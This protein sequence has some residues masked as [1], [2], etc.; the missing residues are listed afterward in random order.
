MK[1]SPLLDMIEAPAQ[2]IVSN[3]SLTR[4]P[5]ELD[6][7]LRSLFALLDDPDPR[8]AEVVGERIRMRGDAVV[9]PLLSFME[10][11]QDALAKE[12]AGKIADEFTLAQI[13]D[14]FRTLTPRFMRHDEQ[15]FEDGVF[16]IARYA[17]PGLDIA[18][19]RRMLDD[20]ASDLKN[21]IAGLS[22]GLEILDEVNNFFFEEQLF[23]G[24]Q[25]K[26]MEPENSY[27]DRVLDRRIGIPISLAAIYL[28]V[29]EYRLRL[30]F[31]GACAPGHFLIRYDGLRAEPLFV[32]AFNGGTVL[33][34]RDIQRYLDSTGLPFHKEF[35][36]PAH[37]RS[38]ILRMM[39]NLLLV[40]NERGNKRALKHFQE[41]M[42]ILSP[43]AGEDM[44]FLRG[45]EG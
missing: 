30:P 5:F 27:I 15:A 35:L 16:L 39:R 36:Q 25:A 45:L 24:N 44:A 8:V 2:S 18:R 12:R 10:S 20:M 31:S 42:R 43:E 32:D 40:F 38:I 13:K 28:L 21:H 14:G 17:N 1:A 33:R 29:V 34:S 19:Y 37:P 26:F 7:E 23:R 11:S 4:A 9:L 22:S 41:F 3:D 6:Q